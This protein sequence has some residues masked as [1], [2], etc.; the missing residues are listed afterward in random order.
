WRPCDTV[1]SALAWACALERIDGPSSLCF[2]RQNLPFQ[3]RSADQ[4]A[5]I[6]RGG[7]VLSEATGAPQVVII[8][9]GSEVALAIAAQKA[10][11]GEGIAVR[12]VSMPSTNVFDRQDAAYKA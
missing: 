1:E 5:A 11:A 9:T 2:S 6:R 3:A 8:A 7:Y 4:V 12:V 10:L